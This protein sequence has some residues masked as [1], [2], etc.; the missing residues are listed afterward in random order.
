MNDREQRELARR[1]A[2]GSDVLDF[3]GALRIVQWRPANAEKLIQMRE[4]TAKRQKAQDR[5][6]ERRRRALIEDFG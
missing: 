1:L 6:R 5:A 4:E 2:A 3:D